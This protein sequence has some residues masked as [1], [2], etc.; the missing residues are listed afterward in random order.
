MGRLQVSQIAFIEDEPL[1]FV[2]TP[3]KKDLDPTVQDFLRCAV[4]DDAGHGAF[5]QLLVNQ[6]AVNPAGDAARAQQC[7]EER[8]LG[9]A[10]AKAVG[11]DARRGNA[12]IGVIAK[13]D[14]VAY[15]VVDGT[16]AFELGKLAPAALVNQ[17][18]DGG[19]AVVEYWRFPQVSI[20]LACPSLPPPSLPRRSFPSKLMQSASR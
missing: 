14:L 5:L 2:P 19:T 18:L 9:V 15:E 17:R 20:H 16:C 11:E 8:S 6:K 12:V 7:H 3:V 10:L 4:I 1:K 13:Q